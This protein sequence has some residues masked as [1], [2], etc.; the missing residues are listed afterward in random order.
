LRPAFFVSRCCQA[1]VRFFSPHFGVNPG[2]S[3]AT[4]K[5]C[6]LALVASR[7]KAMRTLILALA[8]ALSTEAALADDF[9]YFGQPFPT[10][11]VSN[12]GQP[13]MVASYPPNV[14][15]DYVYPPT[16]PVAVPGL[17]GPVQ[18]AGSNVVGYSP[19]AYWPSQVYY[20][21]PPALPPM[22]IP[23]SRTAEARPSAM[24]R[25]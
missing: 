4:I 16:Y 9:Y 23:V 7:E 17:S 10:V 5:G 15:P 22:D 2:T 3:F 12:Y 14:V 25:R 13:A 19:A 11:V 20:R 21:A 8:L 6:S 1:E 24:L 18:I